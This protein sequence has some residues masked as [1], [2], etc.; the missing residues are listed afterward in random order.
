M[1]TSGK[2]TSPFSPF[3]SGTEIPCNSGIAVSFSFE[4]LGTAQGL[5]D[6]LKIWP[7]GKDLRAGIMV[8]SVGKPTASSGFRS[9]GFGDRSCELER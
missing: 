2:D 5:L 8:G 3:P 7:C 4:M 1:G 9:V 6:L